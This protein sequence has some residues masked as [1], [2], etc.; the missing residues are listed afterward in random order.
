MDSGFAC[1]PCLTWRSA[2]ALT[3]LLL[4]FQSY[5]AKC[6]QLGC[7]RRGR[8]LCTQILNGQGRR[9]SSILGNRKLETLA[10]TVAKTASLC[11]PSFWHNTGVW[12][13]NGFAVAYTAL[14]KL[15]LRRAV[16]ILLGPLLKE[17]NFDAF[18]YIDYA[19]RRHIFCWHRNHIECL[20]RVRKI[21]VPFFR[22]LA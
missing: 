19:L 22:H 18:I 6:V 21:P 10:Y 4:R 8:P 7:F 2:N 3:E 16:K 14:A 1:P 17:L 5:E 13:T 12:R 11:V 9:P 20:Q 15:A